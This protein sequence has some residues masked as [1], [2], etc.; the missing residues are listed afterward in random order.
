MSKE[1]QEIAEQFAKDVASHTLEIQLD[2]GVHRSLLL[3]KPSNSSYWYRIVTYPNGLLITGDVG[4]YCFERLNDML[5]FFR[6]DREPN[7]SY[8]HEKV[9]ADPKH[10]GCTEFDADYFESRIKDYFESWC[11]DNK[12][13]MEDYEPDDLW[14]DITDNVLSIEAGRDGSNALQAAYGF[15][16]Q[17]ESGKHFQF[18][19]F[20]EGN[21]EKYTFH[22]IWCCYAIAHAIKMYGAV[23]EAQNGPKS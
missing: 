4:T 9:Q 23:K 19:D 5:E 6:T 1:K 22:Y 16:R 10:T 3:R 12:S 17:L 2:N 8:W 14:T 20:F 13:A 7:L 11:D 15:D 21:F 18:V